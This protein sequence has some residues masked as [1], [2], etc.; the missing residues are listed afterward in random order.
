MRYRQFGKLD[1]KVSALGFGWPVNVL[2]RERHLNLWNF[3]I[4]TNYILLNCDVHL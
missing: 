3:V 1:F 2:L 4:M